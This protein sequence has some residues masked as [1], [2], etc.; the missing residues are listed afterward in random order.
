MNN[1]LLKILLGPLLFCLCLLIG[2][3]GNEQVR[4]LAVIVWMLSWWITTALPIGVTALLPII[5]FPLLG[6]LDLQS[7]TINY[8][9]PVIFLF[10]GGFILG[11]AIEK[12]NLHRRIALNIMHLSG[13]SPRKVILGAMLA[14]SALSMWISNTACTVMMLP[15][16]MS[17]V[18]FLGERI[19][20]PKAARNFGLTLMLGIAYAANI[21]GI[22]TIIGTPP[23]LVLAGIVRESGMPELSFANWLFFALPLVVLLFVVIFLLN[24]RLIFP[25][26]TG[27]IAGIADFIKDELLKLG[28]LG[29]AEKRVLMILCG[30]A[31]LWIF[32][33]QLNKISFLENLSD[34]IIAIVATIV[35]FAWPSGEKAKT[36]LL[37]WEDT[38]RLPWDILYLFGGG[39]SLAKGMEATD[40]VNLAGDFISSSGVVLPLLVILM[41]CA[42]A[43]FLTELMSNVALVSVFIPVSFVIAEN[44]GL[45]ELQL[46]LPL[47]IGASCAFMFPISTPPNAIVFS[48]GFIRMKDMARIG[49]VLNILCILI[50]S[51]YCW[52]LQ[53]YFF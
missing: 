53:G 13:E 15:I 24:T 7:T 20:D 30:T 33:G 31:L 48:S 50:I 40:M 34:P 4:M 5:L 36:P 19:S 35:L 26:R 12:W 9:N 22:A 32:R 44:L 11:L 47:T 16:G 21:G 39:I 18:S 29:T 6:I 45:P 1:R 46:A 38:R 49:L 28:K 37:V 51:V 25:V 42:F 3:A 52:L 8:A 14:T 27:R 2:D 43:V 41:V 10:F 23:N 17:V